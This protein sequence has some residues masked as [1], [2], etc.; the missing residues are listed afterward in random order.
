MG[1]LRNSELGPPP[2]ARGFDDQAGAPPA[3]GGWACD[4]ILLTPS[5]S[6]GRRLSLWFD[7]AHH[8]RSR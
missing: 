4:Q 3:G 1:R 6:S 7:L 5:T 2:L 8:L